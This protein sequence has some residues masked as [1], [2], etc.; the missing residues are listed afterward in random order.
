MQGALWFWCVVLYRILTVLLLRGGYGVRVKREKNRGETV[1][2]GVFGSHGRVR[3]CLPGMT[4]DWVPPPHVC[5][6]VKQ[7]AGIPAKE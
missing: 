4:A 1:E 5:R 3:T 7:L 6:R 2:T